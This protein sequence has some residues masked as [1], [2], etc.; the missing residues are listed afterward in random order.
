[1][2]HWQRPLLW[3]V[4]LAAVAVTCTSDELTLPNEGLPAA[5]ASVSGSGQTGT[6]GAPLPDSLVV[7]IT[8]SEDRPVEGA[9]VV[10]T[11]VLGGGDAIPDTGVTNSDGRTGA[12]WLLGT[13]A[14]TQRVQAMVVGATAG[15]ALTQLFDATALAAPADTIFA[16]RGNNQSAEVNAVLPDSLVVRVTDRFGNPVSATAV[17]WLPTGGGTVSPGSAPTGSTGYSAT[18]RTLGPAAGPQ[19][20]TATAPGLKGSPVTFSSTALPA[21]PTSLTKVSGDGQ[22]AAAGSALPDSLV[23]VLRDVNGNGV[24]GRNVTFAV[25]T[26]GGTTSPTSATT[27]AT[28]R[29]ATRWTLGTAAGPNSLIA[30]SSGFSVTFGATATSAA[31][32]NIAAVS[33]T[34]QTDTAGFPAAAPPSVRVTDVNGNPVAGVSVTFAV[35]GG[36]GSILPTSPIPT[37]AAGTATLSTWTLGGTAGANSVTATVSGLSGS[38]VTFSATGVAGSAARLQVQTQPS[39]AAQSGVAFAVQPAVRLLDVF[40]NAV[41]TGGTVVTAA[42]ASGSGTLGGTLA[43]STSAG[44]ATFTNLA[45]TGPTGAY[46]LQFTSGSLVPDTSAVVTIGAGAATRLAMVTQ[47]SASAQNATAFAQQPRVQVQDAA[48][49]PVAG[50]R[51]VTVAINSGGGVLGGTATINTNGSGLATFAGLSITGSTGN[52][53][54]VFTSAGLTQVISSAVSITAG[55]PTQMVV[56]AGNGQTAT[57]G[58]AVAVPP[59]VVVRDVSNNPVSGVSVTFAVASGG[60]SVLPATPVATNSSGV[61]AATSW[62][63]GPAAGANTLTADA[64]PAGIAGDPV[65]FAATAVAGGAGRLGMVTQ[66]PATSV[67]GATLATAPVVQL[68]D[69]NGNP[70]TTQGIAITVAIGSGPGGAVLGGGTTVGTDATG[71][72]T[73]PGLSITGLVGSY[74]LQ[75]TSPGLTGVASSTISLTPGAATQVT[76]TTQP[77]ATAQSGVAMAPASVAQLQDVSGNAVSS[78][79]VNITATI[80]SGGGTLTGTT[81]VATN[82]AG[83]ASFG[84]LVLTGT[85][86]NRTLS[87]GSA[88]L[89][90]DVS[91]AVNLVAGPAASVRFLQEPTAVVAGAVIAPSPTVRVLDGAGNVV[92]SPSQT[93]ALT[94]STNPGGATLGGTTSVATVSGVATFATL[95]LNRA[96]TGYRLRAAAG[97][98]VPD[99]SAT[100]NVTAGAATTIAANSATAQTDTAGLPVTA[101]PSVLVTDVN[102]NPVA[103]VP[104]TFTVTVGGGSR[105]PVTP[106]TTNASGI[107]A[108]TSWTLGGT[109]GSNTLTAAAAGLTG[110][111]V[112]FSATGV[113]GAATQLV[114][115]TQ[116]SAAAQSGVAFVVQPVVRVADAF[117]N[118]WAAPSPPPPPAASPASPT[119]RCRDRLGPTPSASPPAP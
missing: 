7:R 101:P 68:Q 32:A 77:P 118:T 10:F 6:V 30:T 85:I 110:S 15:G 94:I 35:T 55:A 61:A 88:G 89:T 105:L 86:G 58:S 25:A 93:V 42:L 84:N 103:G 27:D 97:A 47:P 29:A 107:A 26:G 36:G 8:D 17:T 31:A 56:S 78:A 111:P 104:V 43:A 64:A 9:K 21:A 74:T 71:R 102:G 82:A 14:G 49:N 100:F 52:R 69:V 24:P 70:V 18:R 115:Q 34:S 83:A 90:A 23:V 81:T 12:R 57:A 60:G 117:G 19:G 4:A 113:A 109:A 22:T 119:S 41:A 38:P 99:T 63:L 45:I 87:F 54:L 96:G 76:L 44:V 20:A 72:A 98:L 13:T 106:V 116:P 66:P 39:T 67:N 75:F 95:T 50:V 33:P 2:S 48:G 28:G 5:I 1:L 73:F 37:N 79:A 114:I 46:T 92:T 3:P 112:T 91:T 51:S 16:V 62:T 59:S 11:P 80:A 108:L 65:T 53:T 40:G